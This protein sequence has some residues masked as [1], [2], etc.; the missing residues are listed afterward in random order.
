[1]AKEGTEND[2]TAEIN[3]NSL[4]VTN[5]IEQPGRSG[6]RGCELRGAFPEDRI[7]AEESAGTLRADSV[8]GADASKIRVA[9]GKHVATALF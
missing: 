4:E 1:M 9:N 8:P 6:P 5:A 2:L 7:C 3:V